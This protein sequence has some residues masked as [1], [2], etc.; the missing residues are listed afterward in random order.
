MLNERF[1]LNDGYTIPRIGLGTW[2]TP[3]DIAARVV[4]E[5]IEVGYRHIDTAAAYGN[6]KAVGQGVRDSGIAREDIFVTS[7][8]PA[9]IKDASGAR[10]QIEESVGLL[11]LGYIDLMLIHCPVPWSEW[12]RRP[13]DYF[14]ENAAVYRELEKASDEGLVRS[15]GISNFLPHDIEN[16]I[17]NCATV[18]AVDQI[19][20]H[21]GHTQ[22]E[23]LAAC[24]K[25][26]IAVESYS[27]IATG[28]LLKYGFVADMAAKYGVTPAQLC[29][30]FAL[31]RVPITLPK[32]THREYMESNAKVDFVISEADM[33]LL[34][35]MPY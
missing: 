16:I 34:E 6:E 17:Q 19:S 15:I 14:A 13:S 4:R 5:A 28:H 8:I 10:R 30:R 7:K 20:F 23:V 26:G 21:I 31:Q 22:P 24:K 11:G 9:E 27:P 29:V 35:N 12:G 2:Q 33:E 25:H 32:T 1:T 18:P 3:A